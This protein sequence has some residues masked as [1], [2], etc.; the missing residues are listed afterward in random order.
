MKKFVNEANIKKGNITYKNNIIWQA[1]FGYEFFNHGTSGYPDGVT[2]NII[3]ENNICIDAC[4]GWGSNQRPDFSTGANIILQNFMNNIIRNLIIRNNILYRSNE[5]LLRINGDY[6]NND[7]LDIQFYN[8][9]YYNDNGKPVI[10]WVKTIYNS[11]N[12]FQRA[13]QINVIK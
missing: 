7:N 8:N 3:F 5:T 10:H 4:R 6:R 9:Q 2:E 13:T 12:E 11:F 1:E